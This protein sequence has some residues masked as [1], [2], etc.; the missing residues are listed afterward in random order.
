M[1]IVE[2]KN[3]LTFQRENH[4]LCWE[5]YVPPVLAAG[6]TWVAVVGRTPVEVALRSL[7]STFLLVLLVLE[8]WV[9]VG[10]LVVFVAVSICVG[11][12]YQRLWKRR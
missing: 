2:E 4:A 5:H 11:R 6:S 8:V 3:R 12:R 9:E 10:V 7:G 1:P